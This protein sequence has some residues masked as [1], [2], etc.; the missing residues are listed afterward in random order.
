MR[1]G[2][3][4]PVPKRALVFAAL[5]WTVACCGWVASA[6]LDGKLDRGPVA[7]AV[8]GFVGVIW[9]I[10]MLILSLLWIGGPPDGS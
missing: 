10:G 4:D 6:A 5:G 8:I 2:S 3:G 1:G 7:V 9:F